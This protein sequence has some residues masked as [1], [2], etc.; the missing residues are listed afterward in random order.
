MSKF[1][2]NIKANGL[3]FDSIRETARELLPLEYRSKPWLL[4]NQ[5]GSDNNHT[6]YSEEIQLDAYLASYT[7]WHKKN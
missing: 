7:D 3:S 4:T 2:E 6:I 5:G 1:E